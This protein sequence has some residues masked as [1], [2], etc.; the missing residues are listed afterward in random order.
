MPRTKDGDFSIN[1]QAKRD[2]DAGGMTVKVNMKSNT[3]KE[4][5]SK[6]ADECIQ[7]WE[8]FIKKEIESKPKKQIEVNCPNCK[9]KFDVDYDLIMT[10]CPECGTKNILT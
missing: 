4:D 10:D 3:V 5:F 2:K 1:L 7:K 6:L 8:E 9:N